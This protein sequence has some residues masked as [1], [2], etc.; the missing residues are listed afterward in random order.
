M[1]EAEAVT[2]GTVKWHNE[3]LS[4]ADLA[5]FQTL[6]LSAGPAAIVAA[7]M[8]TQRDFVIDFVRNRLLV[9]VA[10]SEADRVDQP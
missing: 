6:A 4:I 8:F 10:G 9:N 7:G 3:T 2:T 5:I 1:F